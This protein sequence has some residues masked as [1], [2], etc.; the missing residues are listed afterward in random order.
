MK[1]RTVIKSL[2]ATVPGLWM[3]N[4]LNA[5]SFFANMNQHEPLMQG[6]LNQHG[7]R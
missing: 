7:I 1:R 4:Q 6:P 3:G 2:A 5:N